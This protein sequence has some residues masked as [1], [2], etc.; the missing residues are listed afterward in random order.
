MRRLD[1]AI[2]LIYALIALAGLVA[3][4]LAMELW[5][6]ESVT[7]LPAQ[8]EVLARAASDS[9]A[10]GYRVQGAPQISVSHGLR[11]YHSGEDVAV[12]TEQVADRNLRRHL[13]S[14]VPPVRLGARFWRATS[15]EGHDGALFLEYDGD[16]KLL[17]ATFGFDGVLGQGVAAESDRFVGTRLARLFFEQIPP[18]PQIHSTSGYTELIYTAGADEGAVYVHLTNRGAWMAFRVPAPYRVVHRQTFAL[19]E[20]SLV[21]QIQIYILLVAA[22]VALGVLMWRLGQRRA[23]ISHALPI[24]VVLLII[25]PP[26]LRYWQSRPSFLVLISFFYLVPVVGLMLAWAV[27]EAETRDVRPRSLVHWDRLLRL[28][29][30][31]ATGLQLLRGLAAGLGLSGLY[32][33]GGELASRFGDGGYGDVLLMLPDFWMMPTPMH[34]AVALTAMSAFI[35]GLGGRLAGRPGAMIGA[36]ITG[37]GWVSVMPVAPLEHSL[38]LG[39]VAAMAAGW[40]LWHQGLMELLIATVTMF[41]VPTAWFVWRHAP[42]MLWDTGLVATVPLLV[43]AGTG[44]YWLLRAPASDDVI[45]LV[46]DYVSALERESRLKAEIGLLRDIQLSL[47]PPERP[48]SEGLDLAWSM[49]PA[50]LVGGDFLDLVEDSTGR[51]WLAVADVAGHGISCSVLTAFTKAA[52]AQY[53]VAGASPSEALGGIRWLFARLQNRR[54]LVTMLLGC[55]EPG[56]RRLRV[57]SAGHP[58][59]L[60]CREGEVQEIGAPTLPLG[61]GIPVEEREQEIECPPGTVIVAYSD[62]VVEAESPDG[63]QL[64]YSAWPEI[65]PSL[66]ELPAEEILQHL[67]AAVDTHCGGRPKGDDVTGL[68]MKIEPN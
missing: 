52:V 30:T 15:P 32:A 10:L 40:L 16:G 55:W 50:D 3:T 22:L 57:A 18:D 67:L 34:R 13:M 7:R 44:F 64:G 5:A 28:R 41:S 58:Q 66:V 11:Q 12:L 49:I 26:V 56:R 2:H 1:P 37:C 33:A 46:P 31:R 35:V 4:G 47:L 51:V 23:G 62:G 24:L 65:L 29:P 61:S 39:L 14:K 63:E 59:L 25:T 53:A 21:V 17:G 27:A 9:Q 19:W 54:A 20:Q 38:L 68:V 36:G 48:Y 42:V 45:T 6:P 43:V 8:S 60:V